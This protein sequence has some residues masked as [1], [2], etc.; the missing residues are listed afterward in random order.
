MVRKI[1]P[2]LII[3]LGVVGVITILMILPKLT[4]VPAEQLNLAQQVVTENASWEP[5]VRRIAGADMV[6]VPAGCFM[7]GST[8]KQ[9]KEA[10]DSCDTYYGAYGCQQSFE[11]EQPTHQVCLSAPYWIDQTTVTNRQYGSSSN[12]KTNIS[13]YRGATWPRETVN[14]QQASDYCAQRGARLPSEAEWDFAA[15]GPDALIYPFG[16]IY[17]IF[18]VTLSKIQPVAVGENP[19]NISWVG[20]LDMAGGIS[21]WVQDWY[22]PYPADTQTN[23]TGPASGDKRVT[24]GGN[25]FAHAVYFVRTT[26]R[27]PMLPNF[28]SSA[29]G[30]RCVQD[31]I[32]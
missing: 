31:F 4:S 15:R 12:Q 22:G 11:N 17:D 24:R 1:F 26:Y 28:A 5:I 7:M 2:Y 3:V 14:W 21:E 20:G 25:W 9:L 8:D 27:E 13:P 19:E 30:F 10:L 23:P 18:K 32:P 29:V 6:R 16:N